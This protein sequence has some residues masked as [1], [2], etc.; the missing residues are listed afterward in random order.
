MCF[1]SR[2]VISR[3]SMIARH[4]AHESIL[5]VIINTR[6]TSVQ[7]SWQIHTETDRHSRYSCCL[8][9]LVISSSSSLS[10]SLSLSSSSRELPDSCL[11]TCNSSNPYKW[12]LF[13][14]SDL[15]GNA[16]NMFR[17]TGINTS[18]N[19]MCMLAR[20]CWQAKLLPL[21]GRPECSAY[22]Q[23]LLRNLMKILQST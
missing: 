5:L 9:P 16:A 8:H 3:L 17:G 11:R 23:I 13:L 1:I 7:T 18:T 10:L 14:F 22:W 4:L 20:T 12:L 6:A 15:S 21:E 2:S 19:T